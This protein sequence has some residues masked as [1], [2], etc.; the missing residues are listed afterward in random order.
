M[1][2]HKLSAIKSVL[3]RIMGIIVLA[4]ITYIFT[5]KW[6]TTTHITFV[7]HGTFLIIF[8]LHERFWQWIKKPTSSIKPWTYEVIL[9]M[10][11]GGLIVYLFTGSFTKVTQITGT[12]TVVKIVMYYIYDK[13]WFKKFKE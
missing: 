13:I 3:W 2:S 1:T 7:H 6:I 8:Y 11:L 10:G 9:G 12:Y 5:R 4:T